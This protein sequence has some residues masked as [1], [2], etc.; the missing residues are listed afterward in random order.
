MVRLILG[1]LNYDIP[2]ECDLLKNAVIWRGLPSDFPSPSTGRYY[3][4]Q[5]SRLREGQAM[6]LLGQALKKSSDAKTVA[7]W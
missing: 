4:D 6:S 5:W 1:F 2:G 3:F 7:R